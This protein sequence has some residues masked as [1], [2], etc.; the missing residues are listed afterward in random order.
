MTNSVA[1]VIITCYDRDAILYEENPEKI[2]P[3]IINLCKEWNQSG[4][5][6]YILPSPF[7]YERHDISWFICRWST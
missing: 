1:L 3:E 4:V 6:T 5:A 7:I 2:F